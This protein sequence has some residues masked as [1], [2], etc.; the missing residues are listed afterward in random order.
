MGREIRRV[1]EGWN[2]PRKD[3]DGSYQP[4]HDRTSTEDFYKWLNEFE[5]FKKN[6]LITEQKDCCF[7]LSDPYKEF[8]EYHGT[9]PD[10]NYFRPSFKSKPVCYQVYETVSEGTPVSPVFKTKQELVD[11]LVENG[12]YWD[13][14]RRKEGG[15][16][17]RCDPW[18][19]EQAERFVGM[20]SSVPSFVVEN[21][22]IKSGLMS[23]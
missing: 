15:S 11:Y 12:D 14:K 2:H 5:K 18:P 1:P 13:Q 3:C 10:Y 16:F 8:C 20:E 19:R 6:E 7:D 23:M 4:M 17:M 9:P 21:G 22:E